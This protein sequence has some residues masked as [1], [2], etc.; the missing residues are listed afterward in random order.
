[1]APLSNANR[2]ETRRLVSCVF[3]EYKF[4]RK[5]TLPFPLYSDLQRPVFNARFSST[6]GLL[7]RPVKINKVIITF[8][9]EP[10]KT[11]CIVPFMN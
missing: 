1:M 10:E 6:K 2:I 8:T 9:F 7:F 4:I 11:G 3:D 5:K